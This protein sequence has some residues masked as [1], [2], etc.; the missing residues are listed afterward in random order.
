[1]DTGIGQDLHAEPINNVL[2]VIHFFWNLE[3]RIN[4]ITKYWDFGPDDLASVVLERH[5]T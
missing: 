2:F 1:M 5:P 4:H 3:N